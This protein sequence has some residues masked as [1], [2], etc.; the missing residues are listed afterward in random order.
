VRIHQRIRRTVL[1][2]EVQAKSVFAGQFPKCAVGL[3]PIAKSRPAT[4]RAVR[5]KN[6]NKQRNN[7]K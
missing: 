2:T 6:I 3:H 7:R 4:Y 5:T 1:R